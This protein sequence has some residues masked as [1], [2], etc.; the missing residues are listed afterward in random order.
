MMTFEEVLDKAKKEAITREEALNLFQETEDHTKAR[1][2]FEVASKVRNDELGTELKCH[3]GIAS[4]LP[5]RLEPLCRYCIYFTDP[6]K[7]PLTLDE[8]RKAAKYL[9]DYGVKDFHIGGGTDLNSDGEEVV[10][11]VEAVRE[12]TSADLTVN[13]G[14]ALS[15]GAIEELKK[16][17]VKNIVSAFETINEEL[18]EKTKPGDSLE[19]KKKLAEMVN[20]AGLGLTS[21][22]LAGLSLEPS[23]YEDYVDLLFYLKS[24]QN[25]RRFYVSRFFPYPGTP[26]ENHQRCSAMEGARIIAIARLVFRDAD[27]STAAG[28]SYDDI[29]LW[30]MAGGGN[31]I[32]GIHINREPHYRRSW[33]LHKAVEHRE[34]MEFV[35]TTP[36]ATKFLKEAGMSVE[37]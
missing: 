27:I 17:G 26:M 11:I 32:M 30:I 34:G 33:Y 2:L 37:Y 28:W 4:C 22:V 9:E 16:L 8:I 3:G 25:F 14:A 35:D 7:E 19:A 31:R 10:E 36:V 15:R 24:F 23:R 12:V 13:V 20:D 21:G 5:C 1:E 29:P 18:F 6:E